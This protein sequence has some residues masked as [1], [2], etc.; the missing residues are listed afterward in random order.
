MA[1]EQY[2]VKTYSLDPSKLDDNGDITPDT[3]LMP[4]FGDPNDSRNWDY[5]GKQTDYMRDRGRVNDTVE[6]I[7]KD[8]DYSKELVAR[9]ARYR[10]A[11]GTGNIYPGE[12]TVT[13]EVSNPKSEGIPNSATRDSY[14]DYHENDKFDDM[15]RMLFN[16]MLARLPNLDHNPYLKPEVAH[17]NRSRA[18]MLVAA[19][20]KAIITPDDILND[21]AEAW[22]D[23]A[24]EVQARVYTPVRELKREDLNQEY[25]Y[26]DSEK[27]YAI[28]RRGMGPNVDERDV[29]DNGQN[30]RLLDALMRA[31]NPASARGMALKEQFD[32]FRS[33]KMGG[34]SMADV[35][36]WLR[37]LGKGGLY[38]EPS[39]EKFKKILP[40]DP[41]IVPSDERIKWCLRDMAAEYGSNSSRRNVANALKDFK[42]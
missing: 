23:D 27:L 30:K 14:E 18:M 6:H 2:F 17:K 21:G 22:R 39:F 11:S 29:L 1:D 16:H 33:P 4:Y 26:P 40:Y 24:S 13:G 8:R 28:L 15:D 32:R 42:Y 37:T 34:I 36:G 3:P 7:T 12:M 38:T 19:P 31:Y 10:G 35:R 5:M 20:K 41:N 25:F 9:P